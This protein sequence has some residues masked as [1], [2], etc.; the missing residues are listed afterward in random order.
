M[1]LMDY[2]VFF[3]NII[4]SIL[5][6]LNNCGKE[7]IKDN[8]PFCKYHSLIYFEQ[9][10]SYY[11]KYLSNIDESLLKEKE[12]NSLKKQK[13]IFI[14]YIKYINTGAIVLLDECFR[15][16]YLVSDQ[17]MSSG[18]GITNDLKF[19]NIGNIE[20]NI[21]RCKIVLTNYE[22]VLSTIQTENQ[23]NEREAICIA[24][25]IKL[26]QIL[27]Y[28]KSKSKNL[29]MLAKRC[30]FIIEKD[31]LDKEKEWCKEFY[32]FY[33]ILN[34]I[35]KANPDEE[36]QEI[37]NRIRKSHGDIFDEINDIFNTKSTEEFIKYI[38]EKHPFKNIKTEISK[39]RNLKVYNT[40]LVRY[41]FEQ[42]QPDNYTHSPE[43]EK[44]ELNYCIAHEISKKLS[45]ALTKY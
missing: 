29:L 42:Y 21:E 36:F 9:A 15:G 27:G 14:D 11:E 41:L 12:M 16:G 37:F 32:K 6:E 8:K 28:L 22:R 44:S 34:D 3:Y 10:K 2:T 23:A 26:N 13:T 17:L 4:I 20:N 1:I 43:D 45:N 24:N 38:L 40:E 35:E 33:V 31:H 19:F 25:I 5:E 39:G 18:R 30:N 7:S